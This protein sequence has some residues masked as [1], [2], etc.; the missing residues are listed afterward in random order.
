M[1]EICCLTFQ[2]WTEVIT[3]LAAEG[4]RP[5]TPDNEALEAISRTVQDRAT[6]VVEVQKVSQLLLSYLLAFM[7]SSISA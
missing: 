5:I 4:L 3:E 2:V 1:F 7:L 6:H